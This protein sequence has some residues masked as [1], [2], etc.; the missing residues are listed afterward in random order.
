MVLPDHTLRQRCYNGLVMPFKEEN[1]Q[2]A[3][4]DLTL[5]NEFMVATNHDIESIDLI[6]KVNPNMKLFKTNK[7]ILHPG[8]FC[9]GSTQEEVSLTDD[10]VGR[11]EGKS[12]LGRLGLFVHVTAGY[13]DPGFTGNITLEL[14]NAANLPIILRPDRPICQISFEFLYEPC[15]KPYN[16][17]YQ[18]DKG[19][20]ESRYGD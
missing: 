15:E 5:S 4:I 8:E 18:G 16:G 19:V 10:I 13:I 2:P 20:V 7:F 9:L 3:S 12:S 6:N 1:L 17:R 14:Y 11:V